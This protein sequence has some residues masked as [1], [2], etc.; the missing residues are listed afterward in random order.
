MS[1]NIIRHTDLLAS[2]PAP[3]PED[4]FP[5]IGRTVAES[6]AKLVILDDDPTGTQTVHGL[7]V[8]TTWRVEV[9]ADELLTPGPGFFILTNSRSLTPPDAARLSQ[10]IGANLRQA[11]AQ[12][13]VPLE[14]I[15]RSDSTLRGHFPG[16]VRALTRALGTPDLPCIVLPFFLEGGRLTANDIHYVAEGEILV[17]AAQTPYARDAVFGYHHSNLREWVV[18]K[19]AGS[20]TQ[21]HVKS[22][23]LEDIRGGGP[24]RVT[25]RL[26]A[27]ARGDFAVVNAVAYSDLA[28]F[29]AGLL[30]AEAQGQGPFVFRSAASFVRVRAGI[31]PR[32][33]LRREELVADNRHGGLFVVGSYVPKTSAQLAALLALNGITAIEIE[34]AQ[35]LDERRQP[36]IIAGAVAVADQALARGRDVVLYTSRDW[37]AADDILGNLDIGRSVSQGLIATVRRIRSQPRYIV[38]KGG[39]TSS[40]VATQGLGVR[41]A[42][43]MGQVLPGV[44]AWKLGPET[45]WPGM[46]YIVFPGNVGDDNALAAIRQRLSLSDPEHNS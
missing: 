4:L 8:L 26:G 3:W 7:P 13:G 39:I 31:S 14:L 33:L 22:I 37:V 40:D 11:I 36:N 21:E 1:E 10:E 24:R 35:L 15:S 44:P 6:S 19:T 25:Q 28:V 5:A 20:V 34:V 41:R 29:V 16:E 23:S 32:D 38:A 27:L 18:E 45:R 9:L 30:A 43:V 17:P 12:T 42:M 2:L 46:A